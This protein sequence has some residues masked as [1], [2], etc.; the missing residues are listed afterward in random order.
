MGDADPGLDY[1]RFV[2]GARRAPPE[3]VGGI[4]GFDEFV[5]AMAK[6]RHPERK[7][8]VEW[9]GRVYDPEDIDLPAV[10]TNIAKLARCHAIGK[11]AFANSRQSER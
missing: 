3:D 4:P 2:D 9:Y 8:L 6:P 11:A 5:E 10:K 7:R 1:P